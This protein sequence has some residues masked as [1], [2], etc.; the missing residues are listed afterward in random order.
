MPDSQ[1]RF[2]SSQSIICN[3]FPFFF[4]KLNIDSSLGIQLALANRSD[5]VDYDNDELKRRQVAEKWEN[6][7]EMLLKY[8]YKKKKNFLL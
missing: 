2:L 3:F 8:V 5:L 1:R 4:S 6:I 7:K